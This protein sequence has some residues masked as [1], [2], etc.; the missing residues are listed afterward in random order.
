MS[1]GGIVTVKSELLRCGCAVELGD[2]DTLQVIVRSLGCKVKALAKVCC[3]GV[4]AAIPSEK[5]SNDDLQE[6][7]SI[8]RIVV[9]VAS[10]GTF[11]L[12]VLA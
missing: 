10:C 12:V 9:G 5:L 8:G 3:G 4:K 6:A 11:L 7:P 1:S 2:D